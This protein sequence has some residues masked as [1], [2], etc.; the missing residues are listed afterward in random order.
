LLSALVSRYEIRHIV[1]FHPRLAAHPSGRPDLG[2]LLGFIQR[3]RRK[4][5]ELRG[6]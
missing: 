2:N 4:G 1:P 3:R 5:K 6:L